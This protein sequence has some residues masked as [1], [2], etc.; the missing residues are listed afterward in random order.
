MIRSRN[1]RTK[2][3]ARAG[4]VLLAI[5]LTGLVAGCKEGTGLSTEELEPNAAFSA[6]V[7]PPELTGNYVSLRRQSASG[8]RIVLDVVVSDV[9]EEV[10]GIALS[11]RYPEGFSRFMGCEDGE[12]F[13]VERE[14]LCREPSSGQLLISRSIVAPEPAVIVSGDRTIVRLEFLVFGISSGPI[15]FQGQNLGGGT[16]LLDAD[17]DPLQVDWFAGRLIGE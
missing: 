6:E 1:E 15:V 5:L 4:V 7:R 8:G 17:G 14:P 16:A 12:L 11:M 9:S 10:S 2:R 13:T 3:R